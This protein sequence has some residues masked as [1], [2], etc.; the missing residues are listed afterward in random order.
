LKDLSISRTT[1]DWGVPVPGDEKHV[2]Y[3]WVDALTNYIT[4][5]GYPDENDEKWSFWPADA[6]IIGKDIV[7]FHAVYWPAFLMSAGI[8]LPKRVFGHGFLFNRGEKMSKSLG[9][10]IDPFTMVEHYGLDQVRYFFLR[11]VPF[12]QDGSYSHEAIVNRTNADLANDLG[13]LAQRSLSMIAK[14]CGAVVPKRGELTEVDEAILDQATAALEIARKAMAEQGIHLALA[15][16]FAVV[17]EAN[18]YF[19][20]QEPWA[21][22]K[23]DP[24]RMETVLWTTAETI[25]RVAILCQPFIPTSA[26]KLLDLL[27]VPADCRNMS[28]VGEGSAL[29]SGVPLPAPTPVFP[30]YVE[31]AEA[32]S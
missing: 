4:G 7:R 32:A 31:P 11:E 12:G 30:R 10:V 17:A 23:T 6:H 19:A 27:A 13:N 14:N 22:K 24:A 25:R 18:R 16:I 15:A 26:A 28:D 20:A 2:M 1:F 3:V 29:A 8:E 5:I 9:N 21:L